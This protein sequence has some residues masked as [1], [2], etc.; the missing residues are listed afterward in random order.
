MPPNGYNRHMPP[1]SPPSARAGRK[2]LVLVDGYALIYRAYHALPPNMMTRGGEPTN[3]AFGFS[4]MVL[5]VLRKEQ[6]DY[7]I[8]AMDRGR[9]FRSDVSTDYK[10]TRPPMPDDLRVQIK[11]CREIATALGLAIYELEGYEADDV[12]GTLAQQAEEQGMDVLVVTGDNDE[13]QLVT[14]HTHVV[15]PTGRNRFNETTEYDPAGVVDKYGFLPERLIDYKAL[16][17]DTSDNIP[18][19]PGVGPKTA[20][21]WIQQYGPLE[22]ILEHLEELKPARAQQ[23]LRDHTDQARQSK[24]LATI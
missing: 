13:L 19:V 23:S 16:I 18:N 22:T 4:Q 21:Q 2:K 6:P 7:S 24:H 14:D 11:R 10:A 12:I 8:L 1:E 15:T 5:D 17:G 20:L 3:A 9:S